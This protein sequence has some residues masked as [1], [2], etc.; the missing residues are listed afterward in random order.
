M[1]KLKSIVNHMRVFAIESFRFIPQFDLRNIHGKYFNDRLIFLMTLLEMIRTEIHQ[2]RMLY[3]IKKYSP[4]WNVP[5]KMAIVRNGGI[6]IDELE[7]VDEK[8]L[9][10]TRSRLEC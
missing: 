2:P 4:I 5:R 10:E 7:E 3:L 9:F 8:Q 6:R 1:T